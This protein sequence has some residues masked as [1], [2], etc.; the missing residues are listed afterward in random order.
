LRP[1][2]HPHAYLLGALANRIRHHSIQADGSEK[3]S[4]ARKN[5]EECPEKSAFPKGFRHHLIHCFHLV[6]RN[7]LVHRQDCRA[8]QVRESRRISL[9]SQHY[10]HERLGIL[11][12][13]V[14]NAGK[15]APLSQTIIDNVVHNPD[16]RGPLQ[17]FAEFFEKR[18]LMPN[19]ISIRK[20]FAR[21]RLVNQR[22]PLAVFVVAIG[23]I[24][25]A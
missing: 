19:W 13:R 10:R 17:R 1:Q 18:E 6:D 11:I 23:K 5:A 7:F 3:E 16:D 4:Q 25:S 12:L 15:L 2:G 22:H 8:R 24:A 20:P 14:V 21:A 9:G